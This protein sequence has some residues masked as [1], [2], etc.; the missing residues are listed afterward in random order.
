MKPVCTKL[1]D[2]HL[3]CTANAEQNSFEG[4]QGLCHGQCRYK[5]HDSVEDFVNLCSFETNMASQK[6]AKDDC[7]CFQGLYSIIGQ[8]SHDNRLKYHL[9]S[10]KEV[11]NHDFLS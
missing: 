4:C 8:Y 6:V 7:S 1:Y 9:G 11:L 5:I 2:Q 10:A 3:D